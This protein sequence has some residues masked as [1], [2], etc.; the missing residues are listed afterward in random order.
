MGVTRGVNMG[1]WALCL[2]FAAGIVVML[3]AAMAKVPEVA[4][5]AKVG[6]IGLILLEAGAI[7]LAVQVVAA[8]V[9]VA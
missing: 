3:A 8:A 7:D 6:F 2:A 5:F 9:G 4:S 1:I